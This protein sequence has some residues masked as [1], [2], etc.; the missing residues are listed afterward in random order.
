MKLLQNL[1]RSKGFWF[2]FIICV[3]FFLLRFPSLFE[4]YWYG[5]EGVYHVLGDAINNGRSLYSE[6]WDNKPPLL[7][8]I[9]SILNSDQFLVRS[10]SLVFGLLSVIVFYIL[11]SRLFQNI[12]ASYISTILFSI[13]FGLPIL[14]GNIA[15]TENF[16]LL[17]I[18]VSAFFV[19]KSTNEKRNDSL[20]FLGGLVLGLAFIF[21]ILAIFDFFA[22]LIFLKFANTNHSFKKLANFCIGFSLPF[23]ITSLYFLFKGNFYPY[24]DAVLLSNISYVGH[25]NKFIIP[26][27]LLIFKTLILLGSVIALL[28][29]R[30][31]LTRVS[32]FILLWLF[33]SIFNS[34]FSQRPYTHYLLLLLPSFSLLIGLIYQES[35]LRKLSL[36]LLAFVLFVVTTNFSFF[37]KTVFYY[38]NFVSFVTENKSLYSYQRFFDDRTPTDYEIAAYVKFHTDPEDSIF[39]WGDNP[40]VYSLSG[41]L[42]PGRYATAYHALSYKEGLEETKK[43]LEKSNPK[44]IIIM[45]YMKTFPFSLSNYVEKIKIDDVTIYE[46]I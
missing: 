15:N 33:F 9:Y 7:H 39:I 45:P 27:G 5:D 42:P 30:N 2:I 17:P 24:I 46:H 23:L 21:K 44:L 6:A 8:I 40:Q 4:P 31:F 19:Y 16:M 29:K 12:K 1:E 11:S 10:L 25:G 3:F 38:Q 36:F 20:I 32:L 28:L 37:N 26:Q 41:K 18:L 35:K 43:A 13:L 34:F 22:F 14:E